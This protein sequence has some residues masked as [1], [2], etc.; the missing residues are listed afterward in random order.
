MAILSFFFVPLIFLFLA[1]RS[2][3]VDIILSAYPATAPTRKSSMYD[4]AVCPRQPPG[5][6]CRA[7][8]SISGEE[9]IIHNVGAVDVTFRHLLP[10]DIAAVFRVPNVETF[11]AA[12]TR[13]T[14]GPDAVLRGGCSGRVQH[15]IP[16]PGDVS[17]SSAFIGGASYISLGQAQLPPNSKTALF[18]AFQGVLGLVWGG[19]Q[20]F[21]SAA[22]QDKFGGHGRIPKQ[23][24]GLRLVPTGT[25]YVQPPLKWVY[26]TYLIA[27]GTKY[28]DSGTGGLIYQSANGRILNL[29][30]PGVG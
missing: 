23:R 6:C 2:L 22:A 1:A 4:V 11:Y 24:R 3:Q 30:A 14:L 13:G 18:L 29:S 9:R 27:N 12:L 5:V 19:G 28:T 26:P 7:P 16:G 15:S 21:A 8:E 20:W 17:Y 25:A 10:G